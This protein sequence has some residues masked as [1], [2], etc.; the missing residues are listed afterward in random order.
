MSFHGGLLGVMAALIVWSKVT[1][2]AFFKVT[3][4]L[5][6]LAPWALMLGRLGNFING[7]LYG[8][9][10]ES[11]NWCLN[12]P[13]DIANCR[14][15][16]QLFEAVGEGP[17]L[18]LILIMVA[19]RLKG[20]GRSDGLL[21]A[22]FLAGYGLIR[23]TIEFWREPDVQIGYFWNFFTEGQLLSLGMI[24]VAAALFIT[25]WRH[26]PVMNRS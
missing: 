17:L 13:T 22:V 20:H 9:I 4:A 3:D 15:P 11:G 8:R 19:R 10:S 12:F 6:L 1:R 5:V 21:S 23:F 24:G 2:H 25:R 16:S 26:D 14:Y 18:F 7:E